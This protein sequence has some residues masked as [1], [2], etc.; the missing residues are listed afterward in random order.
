MSVPQPSAS[1]RPRRVFIVG[2]RRSGTTWSM[3]LL[4]QH[5]EVVALQQTDFFRRLAHFGRWFESDDP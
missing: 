3:L 4:A 5:S 1:G 2:C